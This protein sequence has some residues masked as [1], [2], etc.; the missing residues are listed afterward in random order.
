MIQND[1]GN[2]HMLSAVEQA[3]FEQRETIHAEQGIVE[4]HRLSTQLLLNGR[5]AMEGD[6]GFLNLVGLRTEFVLKVDHLA[7]RR[8]CH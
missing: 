3:V 4:T 6:G 2:F 7:Q 8:G 5:H 1:L